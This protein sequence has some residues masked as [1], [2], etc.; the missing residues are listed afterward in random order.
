[1]KYF[2]T[3]GIR[4]IYGKGVT[5][6]L[7]HRAGKALGLLFGGKGVIGRDTRTSGPSLEDALVSGITSVGVDVER[8]GVL[9]T[10][11]VSFM[12]ET[13]GGSFGV[14]ISASHNPPEYNGLKVFSSDGSKISASIEEGIEYYM[15]NADGSSLCRGKSINS[16]GEPYVAE[17]K[18]RFLQFAEKGGLTDRFTGGK[19]LLDSGAGAA[20]G[21]AEEVFSSLGA[22]VTT[23]CK[24]CRGECINLRCGA[25]HPEKMCAVAKGGYDIGLSFDGDAD[26]MVAWQ[27]GLLDGD[28]VMLNLALAIRPSVVVGTVMTNSAL[29][30]QLEK[31]GARFLRASVGD[32]SVYEIMRVTGATLGGEPSGH[33]ILGSARTGDGILSGLVLC[34]LRFTNGLQRLA[35]DEKLLVSVN[36]PPTVLSDERVAQAIAYAK[37]LCSRIVVRP[38]GTEPV[39]RVMAE[40]GDVTG[41]VEII[42]KAIMNAI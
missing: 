42:R 29:G 10:P 33:Y 20:S 9:T 2:G 32:R 37:R 6:D 22:S 40:G 28:E 1:M 19:I 7:A 21:I 13:L 18:K 39:L 27:N 25:L 34:A 36:A 8:V 41:S 12:T 26:R 24:E 31:T 14:A 35:L 5:E 38:S 30:R 16:S 4:G 15:D 17:L 11:G 23:L 3:D